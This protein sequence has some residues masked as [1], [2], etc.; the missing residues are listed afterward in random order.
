MAEI[1]ATLKQVLAQLED[2]EGNSSGPRSITTF[3]MKSNDFRRYLSKLGVK[4]DDMQSSLEYIADQVEK[5]FINHYFSDTGPDASE[6]G[7]DSWPDYYR[8]G[9]KDSYK[10]WKER[11]GYGDK[12]LKLT[13]VLEKSLYPGGA[14]HIREVSNRKLEVGTEVGHYIFA[15]TGFTGKGGNP[16]PTDTRRPIIGLTNEEE[17]EIIQDFIDNF[18]SGLD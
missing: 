7:L 11:K 15:H 1:G 3:K 10:A 4:L 18:F 9:E 16:T 14:G 8:G 12:L 13:G 2:D 5:T 17:Q 6:T